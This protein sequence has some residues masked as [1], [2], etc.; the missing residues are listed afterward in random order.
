MK[1]NYAMGLLLVARFGE[2]TFLAFAEVI[3]I[4]SLARIYSIIAG[5]HKRACANYDL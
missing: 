2:R 3:H 1:A 5:F 4:G